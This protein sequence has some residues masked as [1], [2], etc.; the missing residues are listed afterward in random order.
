MDRPTLE[1]LHRS[2]AAT[3]AERTSAVLQ[4]HGWDALVIHSGTPRKKTRVDDNYWPLRPTPEFQHW[5]PLAEPG[6]GIM[7][8]TGHKPK[9]VRLITWSFWED[10]APPECDHFWGSFEVVEV[11]DPAAIRQHVPAGRVAFIG[12]DLEAASS[13]GI[14]PEAA[15]PPQLV[16]ALD[17]LRVQK[18]PYEVSCIAEANRRAAPGHEQLRRLFFEGDR[19][20][21][22][23]HL[24]FLDATDQDDWE[25]PYKNI[26]ALDSHAATLHHVSYDKRAHP[27][28]SLLVD[29]AAA[30][31]GYAADVTRTWVKGR[32]A[33]ASTF[34]QLVSLV[35]A[36][37]QRLCAAVRIAL[38]YEQLHDESHRQVGVI[39]RE[40]GVVKDAEAAV[41]NGI[42][43]VFYLHGLGHALGLQ[44]HDVGCAVV[45]PR[46]DNPF[47]RNTSVIAQ[48]QVFTIEPGVYF[49]DALIAELREGP[50]A[51]DVD[52][53]VVDALAAF[54]GVRIEDDL[55]VRDRGIRN[56]TREQLGDAD[57]KAA[58]A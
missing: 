4:Q 40:V 49:I 19:S 46:P 5:A 33:A 28:Q 52:W 8:Q 47:L 56:L 31:A 29:A 37:Q 21:L 24:A 55:F 20:E 53:K 7:L 50:R 38:P 27:A 51:R 42:T 1:T 30:F 44:V 18:T 11:R 10:Q 23:L 57:R 16:A 25:T 17:Q 32:G 48:D 39:L 36:M 35:E 14:P 54:G 9:L 22:E 3:L 58:T 15:N 45:P 13:W 43:R 12:D 26:V 6:C 2:H 34:A 41:A